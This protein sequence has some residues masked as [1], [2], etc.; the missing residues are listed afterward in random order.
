MSSTKRSLHT[1]QVLLQGH[2]TL[3]R[4]QTFLKILASNYKWQ[5]LILQCFNNALADFFIYTKPTIVYFAVS[6]SRLSQQVNQGIVET[7]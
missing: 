3:L 4:Q 6:L 7:L 1:L 5:I 2:G